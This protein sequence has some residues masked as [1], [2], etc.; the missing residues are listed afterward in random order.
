MQ[1][2][3][4]S[5]CKINSKVK[6][7]IFLLLLLAGFITATAQ[8]TYNSSG[9]NGYFYKKT[10]KKVRGYDPSK[11]IVGGIISLDYSSTSYVYG[12][13]GILGYKLADGI[14]AGI[15]LGYQK[16]GMQITWVDPY[17]NLTD[18]NQKTTE[19]VV[20][21]GIWGRI[22]VYRN[23]YAVAN[24][25]YDFI[26]YKEADQ[27]FDQGG[28]LAYTDNNNTNVSVPCLLVGAGVKEPLGGRAS[29]FLELTYDVLQQPYSPYFGIPV[30][31]TGII[32]GL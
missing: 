28:N 25:E 32:V 10:H 21:P 4:I 14:S 5:L 18:Q 19:S 16:Y 3:V 11:L 24:F 2:S 7:T 20:N 23:I 30:M 17:T 15:N 13:S 1:F 9:S 29:L 22:N 6:R 31:R 26:S 8:E 27:Y 12:L